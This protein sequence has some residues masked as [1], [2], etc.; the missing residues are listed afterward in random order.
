S[1]STTSTS[2]MTAKTMMPR[3]SSRKPASP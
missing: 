1:A 3:P 2:T